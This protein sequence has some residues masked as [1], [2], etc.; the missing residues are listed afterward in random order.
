MTRIQ[1]SGDVTNAIFFSKV[2]KRHERFPHSVFRYFRPN[3]RSTP[4]LTKSVIAVWR[5][6]PSVL[7]TTKRTRSYRI[8]HRR[9]GT[10]YKWP[11]RRARHAHNVI[12]PAEIS[13][14][15]DRRPNYA[16]TSG[17]NNADRHVHLVMQRQDGGARR[18]RD[19]DSDGDVDA[20]IEWLRRTPHLPDVA[21]KTRPGGCQDRVFRFHCMCK[22]VRLTAILITGRSDVVAK[23]FRRPET[24]N[25]TNQGIAGRLLLLQSRDQRLFRRPRSARRRRA[26]G[27]EENVS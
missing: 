9:V 2:F 21:G 25:G 4:L 17:E 1:H 26:N 12:G 14:A 18:P 27:H 22:Y 13:S 15:C 19:D 20:L 11:T 5:N 6:Q 24:T 3:Q 7:P 8:R 23:L 16:G 10:V